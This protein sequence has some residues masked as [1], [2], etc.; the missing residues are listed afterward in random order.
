MI[1]Q[2][3]L[4]LSIIV[5]ILILRPYGRQDRVADIHRNGDQLYL[6]DRQEKWLDSHENQAIFEWWRAR[7]DKSG[8]WE[9][10]VC[11]P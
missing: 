6:L 1:K 11:L 7:Q 9:L 8:H 3:R 2:I 10:E 4:N 5:S